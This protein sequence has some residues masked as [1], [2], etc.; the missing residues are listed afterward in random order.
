MT[1]SY[2]EV[3]CERIR[4]NI[5]EPRP[6]GGDRPDEAACGR[7]SGGGRLRPRGGPN[8]SG[9]GRRLD[10]RAADV[11]GSR[12]PDDRCLGRCCFLAVSQDISA[13]VALRSMVAARRWSITVSPPRRHRRG[14]QPTVHVV[15]R[16]VV[17]A[18]PACLHR[19]SVEDHH[20]RVLGQIDGETAH[21]GE[22]ANHFVRKDGG[23]TASTNDAGAMSG[24]SAPPSASELM[25]TAPMTYVGNWPLAHAAPAPRAP[26]GQPR[27][28]GGPGSPAQSAP[29]SP[30]RGRLS[31]ERAWRTG[32]RRPPIHTHAREVGVERVQLPVKLGTHG[33][34]SCR[35][36]S[37]RGIVA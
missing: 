22:L 6:K 25:W 15:H 5:G 28:A 1:I 16:L 12:R 30:R 36:I 34:V 37:T 29:P 35:G 24:E 14:E 7:G 9:A 8:R 19:V 33:A 21:F 10:R 11:G 17:I 31:V 4:A 18:D 26:Y 27:G 13:L 2:G 23:W 20:G 32:W 3:L